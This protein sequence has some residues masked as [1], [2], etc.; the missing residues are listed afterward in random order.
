MFFSSYSLLTLLKKIEW[1]VIH[2]I[3]ALHDTHLGK[4]IRRSGKIANLVIN[5][6][7]MTSSAY[8]F[9]I[10][11]Y[12][13][14]ISEPI[15]T[16][17]IPKWRAWWVLFR[18]NI[19]SGHDVTDDVINVIYDVISASKLENAITLLFFNRFRQS[20]H[21]NHGIE[22]NFPKKNFF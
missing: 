10:L 3:V 18:K 2:E 14:V 12:I 5:D 16:I 11:F 15:E 13:S 21:Q 1:N 7:I 9:T 17:H 4:I 20:I 6:V 8:V 19:V 22:M